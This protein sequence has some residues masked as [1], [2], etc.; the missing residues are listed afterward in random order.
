MFE[1]AFQASA[2]SILESA[3]VD[4]TDTTSVHFDNRTDWEKLQEQDRAAIKKAL[5]VRSGHVGDQV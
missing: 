3:G 1:E 5:R 2:G 4:L